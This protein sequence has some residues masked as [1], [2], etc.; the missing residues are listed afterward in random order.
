MPKAYLC[1]TCGANTNDDNIVGVSAS[2]GEREKNP[3][4]SMVESLGMDVPE[5]LRTERVKLANGFFCS[6]QCAIT[7]L[8]QMIASRVP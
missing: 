3:M 6:P 5:E 2:T 7:F 1:D 4:L 8:M